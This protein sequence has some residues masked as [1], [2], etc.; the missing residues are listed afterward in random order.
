MT[1]TKVLQRLWQYIHVS[2]RL[3]CTLHSSLQPHLISHLFKETIL[4]K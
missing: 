3:L 1:I 4:Q 2:K